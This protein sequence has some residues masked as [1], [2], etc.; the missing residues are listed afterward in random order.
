MAML[1]TACSSF[2]R[3]SGNWCDPKPGSES[4]RVFAALFT[5]LCPSSALRGNQRNPQRMADRI[6]LIGET[7]RPNR[8]RARLTYNSAR[9]RSARL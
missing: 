3:N 1:K 9:G 5:P 8:R 2:S 7:L 6:I 4:L